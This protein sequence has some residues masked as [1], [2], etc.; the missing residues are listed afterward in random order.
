MQYEYKGIVHL[1][2]RRN[3]S[4]N[5]EFQKLYFLKRSQI[6]LDKFVIVYLDESYFNN[7][8]RK[9]RRWL[10]KSNCSLLTNKGRLKSVNLMLSITNKEV[11]HYLLEQRIILPNLFLFL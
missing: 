3:L 8:K 9:T 11:P 7:F 2:E 1:N 5:K 6:N 4:I 10:C